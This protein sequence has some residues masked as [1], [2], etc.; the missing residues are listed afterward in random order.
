M[1]C[2]NRLNMLE[3][4]RNVNSNLVPDDLKNNVFM[5]KIITQ[6][7]EVQTPAEVQ[8]LL[9]I[10]VDRIGS[11]LISQENWKQ[12]TLKDSI[13][14]VDDSTAE[15]SLIPLFSDVDMICRILDYY[16]PDIVHFCEDLML[17]CRIHGDCDHLV[18][19]Q[20]DVKSRFPDIKIMRSIPMARPGMTQHISPRELSLLF[21]P[22][23]DYFLTD[24]MITK[25]GDDFFQDQPV[26]GFVGITGLTCDWDIAATLVETSK[27][28]VI[29]AGGLAP[30]NVY[31][32]ILQVRPAGVDSCTK[33]N[34][35]DAK[36]EAIR[37]K[38]D[39]DKVKRFVAEVRRAERV[40]FEMQQRVHSP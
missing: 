33:T 32:A 1:V 35:V 5:K 17:Q 12:Q 8:H 40:I 18:L 29:L 6:I 34:A 11:V 36:G 26:E 3:A 2:E 28:P 38:K 25:S 31:D 27:I 23:S 16:R 14:C 10:G 37:F 9:S 13:R 24:T 39:L 15:S 22:V 21:E 7:Y 30:D 19:I 4:S 20:R